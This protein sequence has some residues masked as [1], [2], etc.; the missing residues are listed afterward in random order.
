[1]TDRIAIAFPVKYVLLIDEMTKKG[2]QEFW[3]E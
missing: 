1:M 2:H 3:Q